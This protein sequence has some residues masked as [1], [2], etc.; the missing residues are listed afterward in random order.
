[1]LGALGCTLGIML[2]AGMRVIF[3]GSSRRGGVSGGWEVGGP[4][5]IRDVKRATRLLFSEM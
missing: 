2:G 3:E 5:Y 4:V 1:M